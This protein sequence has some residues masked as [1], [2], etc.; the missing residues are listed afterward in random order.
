MMHAMPPPTEVGARSGG[1]GGVHHGSQGG[2]STGAG[3][4]IRAQSLERVSRTVG[5]AATAIQA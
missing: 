3:G 1:V 4:S 5:E 2:R